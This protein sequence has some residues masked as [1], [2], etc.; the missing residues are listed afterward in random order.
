MPSPGAVFGPLAGARGG[1]ARRELHVVDAEVV[2]RDHSLHERRVD[3]LAA[4]GGLARD[5]RGEDAAH[6]QCAAPVLAV[7]APAK[8]GP[9]RKAKMPRLNAPI[10][11][12]TTP[13]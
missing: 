10:F 2:G 13:S 5:Q 12:C 4:P 8:I 9:S 1:G 3:A 6:R 7:G 11:A